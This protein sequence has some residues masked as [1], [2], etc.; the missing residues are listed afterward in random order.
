[1][2]WPVQAVGVLVVQP[3]LLLHRYFCLQVGILVV[4]GVGILVAMEVGILVAME[5]GILLVMEVG[6]L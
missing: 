4:M 3:Q 5:V 1:M 6:I 2:C